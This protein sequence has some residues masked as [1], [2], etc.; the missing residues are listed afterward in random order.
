MSDPNQASVSAPSYNYAQFRADCEAYEKWQR[1]HLRLLRR[2]YHW[3]V[4]FCTHGDVG[5]G[6]TVRLRNVL[7]REVERWEK[8]TRARPS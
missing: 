4:K 6:E 1:H 3:F 7:R 8:S 2:L 5:A